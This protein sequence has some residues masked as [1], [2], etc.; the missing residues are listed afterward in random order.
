M[1]LL[2]RAAL[3]SIVAVIFSTGLVF[4]QRDMISAFEAGTRTRYYREQARLLELQRKA[5]EAELRRAELE[6]QQQ[7]EAP[8]AVTP[9]SGPL[10]PEKTAELQSLIAIELQIFEA[11]YPDWSATSAT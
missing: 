1:V 9:E 11:K 10:T 7:K 5:V 2:R 8:R 4:S 6:L 3:L